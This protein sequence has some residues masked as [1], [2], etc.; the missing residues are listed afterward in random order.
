M[1]RPFMGSRARVLGFDL[2]DNL[3]HRNN[4]DDFHNLLQQ[5]FLSENQYISPQVMGA[6]A[7]ALKATI[8]V[9][10]KCPGPIDD[11]VIHRQHQVCA[12]VIGITTKLGGKGQL[13]VTTG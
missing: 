8:V 10:V 7:T 4:F 6:A 5:H 13:A 2:C 1:L 11:L 12:Y 3:Q 9:W